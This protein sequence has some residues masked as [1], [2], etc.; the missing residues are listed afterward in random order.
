MVLPGSRPEQNEVV[1]IFHEFNWFIL[2]A[3]G[4]M[5]QQG[6]VGVGGCLTYGVVEAESK[7]FHPQLD[8]QSAVK[9]GAKGVQHICEMWLRPTKLLVM[10]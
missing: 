7:P 3:G 6:K 5:G 2:V 9:Q 10:F 1:I 8:C 4:D